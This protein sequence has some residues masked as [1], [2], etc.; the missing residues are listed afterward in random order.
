MN[1]I[2]AIDLIVNRLGPAAT[3]K[4]VVI[5]PGDDS[6]VVCFDPDEE[7]VVTSDV[8][9]EKRHF[10]EGSPGD[11][12][13]YRSVSA[14][15][16]DLSSMG[17][18]PRYLTIALTVDSIE[19]SWL[20]AFA[21]GVRACCLETGSIVIGGNLARGPKS[22]AITALGSVLRGKSVTRSGAEV[23]DEIWLTGTVGATAIA[24]QSF[25]DP[26]IASLEELLERRNENALARYFLPIPRVDFAS[27]LFS[28]A[29]SAT[30]VSDGLVCELDQLSRNSGHRMQVDVESVPVWCGANPR[31]A[32]QS[33][34]SY[35][36]VFTAHPCERTEVTSVAKR[37]KTPVA[38]IGLVQEGDG[39]HVHEGEVV[40][41]VDAGYS[42]F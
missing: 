5:G 41:E 23:G 15:I 2:E 29:S 39:V 4:G 19:E 22:I 37:T 36:L 20:L 6:A 12:V 35:E 17:A 27:H 25:R 16:S 7:T 11:L 18:Q 24:L 14:N 34:D 3:G 38:R 31:E 10:P 21:D 1:E 28:F 9:V 32:I 8:L 40:I 26:Q 33:D 30:D 42:H 13:G